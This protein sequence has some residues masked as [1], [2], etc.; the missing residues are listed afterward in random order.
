MNY[1]YSKL[2][3][4]PMSGQ[5]LVKAIKESDPKKY[6][7][8]SEK[9]GQVILS[10][11]VLKHNP[12]QM[13]EF[14]SEQAVAFYE[15]LE[16]A[17]TE[18]VQAK[19]ENEA[20]E[21]ISKGVKRS[22]RIALTAAKKFSS[23]RKKLEKQQVEQ[24][25]KAF[26]LQI[27]QDG[28]VDEYR[29]QTIEQLVESAFDTGAVSIT[30]KNEEKLTRKEMVGL[31]AY[32]AQQQHTAPWRYGEA[33]I[34]LRDRAESLGIQKRGCIEAVCEAFGISAP[35]VYQSIHLCE[36]IPNVEDRTK[37]GFPY[38]Y[39]KEAFMRDGIDFE[40]GMRILEEIKSLVEASH[41]V[42]SFFVRETAKETAAQIKAYQSYQERKEKSGDDFD[43]DEP[44]FMD[45]QAAIT[46]VTKGKTEKKKDSGKPER[47]AAV[48]L[49]AD[50]LIV[51]TETGKARWMQSR[52]DLTTELTT[53][54]SEGTLSIIDVKQGLMYFQSG[55]W[56][57]IEVFDS[58]EEICQD[59]IT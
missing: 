31:F 45:I 41:P 40:S 4:E 5:Q 16:A 42:D 53:K 32:L 56:H 43:E 50:L 8:I 30:V 11:N 48:G 27:V 17:N 10:E 9:M 1:I 38:T 13:D 25:K 20:N 54:A 35:S 39:Y 21:R 58:A 2:S 23:E 51:C 46:K 14:T 44:T 34:L 47:E 19:A 6:A 7:E 33:G 22:K 55:E 52:N 15:E 28:G 59:K 36:M 49:E 18:T 29:S 12:L 3:T 37:F 57:E 26:S 24:G